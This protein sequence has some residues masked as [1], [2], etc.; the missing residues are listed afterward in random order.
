M[1]PAT[2][3]QSIFQLADMALLWEEGAWGL[4]WDLAF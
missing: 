2:P 3:V 4:D 1:G